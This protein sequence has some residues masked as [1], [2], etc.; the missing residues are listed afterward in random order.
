MVNFNV[1]KGMN[2]EISL[3]YLLD[4]FHQFLKRGD[5]M[6]FRWKEKCLLAAKHSLNMK[7]YK[8]LANSYYKPSFFQYFLTTERS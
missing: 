6:L 7:V 8:T 3:D 5:E 4:Y 1:T 2:Q